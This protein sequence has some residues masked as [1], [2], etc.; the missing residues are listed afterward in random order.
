MEAHTTFPR[1]MFAA[2]LVLP[3]AASRATYHIA[4][5]GVP[6]C[7]VRRN[8]IALSHGLDR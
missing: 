8:T 3:L 6:E 7:P 4:E 1:P 5:E 2:S